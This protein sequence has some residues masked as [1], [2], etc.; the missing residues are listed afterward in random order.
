MGAKVVLD[1][2]VFVSALG[3]EGASH[4]IF[5]DCIGGDLE[6]FLSVE[7]FDELKRVLNY[8]EFKF[9]QAE[10]D[11]FLDQILEVASLV[12]TEIRVDIIKDD[13]SDNKFLECAITMGADYII[14]RDPHILKIKE[15]EGIKIKSPEVFREDNLNV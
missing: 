10:I 4:E 2:N 11:E 7:I 3:W 5:N 9:S 12:E 1:T 14:S 6:L 8:P 15:F 13:P